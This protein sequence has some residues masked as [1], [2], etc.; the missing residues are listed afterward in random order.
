MTQLPQFRT[1]H[2]RSVW[3]VASLKLRGTNLA[4]IAAQ[5]GWKRQT[6]HA[7]LNSPRLPQEEAIAEALG[8]EPRALWP[9]RY[10]EDG[11]RLH[12]VRSKRS[13]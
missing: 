11:T 6:I 4:E 5:R 7:A 3:V 12:K 2:E 9:E 1:P 10:R 13:A 8:V